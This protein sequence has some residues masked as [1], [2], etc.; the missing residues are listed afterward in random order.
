MLGAAS[1]PAPRPIMTPLEK[2]RQDRFCEFHGEAGHVTNE[3]FS[4]RNAI[5]DMVAQGKMQQFVMRQQAEV[6]MVGGPSHSK[7]RRSREVNTL[8]IGEPLSRR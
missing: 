2:R 8:T 4:L 5:E 6:N 1:F 3:C 7:K